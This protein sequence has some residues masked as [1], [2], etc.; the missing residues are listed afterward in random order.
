MH[1][2]STSIVSVWVGCRLV[3][4]IVF[5]KCSNFAFSSTPHLLSFY[6]FVFQ[7]ISIRLGWNEYDIDAEEQFKWRSGA[8]EED[9][10]E[11]NYYYTTPQPQ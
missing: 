3:E 11:R 4:C 2:V 9:A 6:Y 1:K 10:S 8:E 5:K 7:T